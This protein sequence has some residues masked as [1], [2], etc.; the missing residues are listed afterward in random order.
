MS[1]MVV[2]STNLSAVSLKIAEVSAA[3]ANSLG[4]QLKPHIDVVTGNSQSR[5]PYLPS[6]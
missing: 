4:I 1:I 5:I 2:P 6:Q 3:V